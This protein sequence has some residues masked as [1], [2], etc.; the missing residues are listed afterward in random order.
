MPDLEERVAALED[1]IR[2]PP[3]FVQSAAMS[4]DDVARFREKLDE[5]MRRT[6]F[7]YRCLP[8]PPPLAPDEIR[9]LLR[10]CA[11]VVGPGETLVIRDRNWTPNQVR[12]IQRWMDDEYESGRIGFKVLAVI[13][14]ELGVAQPEDARG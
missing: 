14:E 2:F 5:E 8:P 1:L 12:E 13:G 6:P 4:D 11:T 7:T 10:E 9:H 3:Q